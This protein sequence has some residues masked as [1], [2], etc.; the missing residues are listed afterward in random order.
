M[1]IG[2]CVPGVGRR[3]DIAVTRAGRAAAG[4]TAARTVKEE[5]AVHC[6]WYVELEEWRRRLVAMMTATV[7]HA[8][9]TVQLPR[10][11]TPVVTHRRTLRVQANKNAFAEVGSAQL[12]AAQLKAERYV[13][14]NR[15]RV[16]PGAGPK[17]EKR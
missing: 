14:T 10:N 5:A 6:M 11:R 13:A 15:F 7:S 4:A 1:S 3:D 16:K 9:R 17:F 8:M 12:D 2:G